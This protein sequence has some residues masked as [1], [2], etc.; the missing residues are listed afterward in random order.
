MN[1][2]LSLTHNCNLSCS[3]C[4]A[5]EKKQISISK[6]VIDKAID[7]L[8]EQSFNKLEFGFFGG[9]PLLEWE[10][11]K[12]S[13]ERIKTI[14]GKKGIKTKQTITTNGT[15]LT[16]EKVEWLKK[17][18]FYMVISLDGD[19]EMNDCH[20][21]F[22]NG[23]GAFDSIIDSLKMLQKEYKHG[24]YAINMVLT[25][26]NIKYFSKSIIELYNKYSIQDFNI[27]VDF[28]SDWD[29]YTDIWESEFEKVGD[30]YLNYFR[31]G[32]NIDI[33]FLE[34]KIKTG[35]SG[36]YDRCNMCSFGANEII[37]AP[38]G[39]I[40]PCERVISD[41]LDQ[42]MIIGN[43]FSGFDIKKRSFLLNKRGNSNE[44]CK[45]CKL[46]PRCIN[47][48]GCTNYMMTKSI[49]LTSGTL[50]YNEKLSIKIADKVASTLFKEE[51]SL[52]LK[53][54]YHI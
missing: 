39:N 51:N 9:E 27:A 47:F 45:S 36:G 21:V 54:F 10:L 3:Y 23:I 28:S 7:F 30:I 13:T 20:R 37:V 14:A 32:K 29:D 5:G 43:V 41:D 38:S 46:Q 6:E 19:R 12:Y 15:L 17:E 44:E 53:K 16:P 50:C 4:Y 31:E 40:Y 52:F 1:F 22:N 48:C 34:D 24:E 49:D 18:R 11:L 2:T 33:S 8:F 35:I 25:P 42:N 26:Q